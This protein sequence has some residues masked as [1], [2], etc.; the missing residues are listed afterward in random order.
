MNFSPTPYLRRSVIFPFYAF[1]C[2][3][4]YFNKLNSLK[5]LE[6]PFMFV[7]TPSLSIGQLIFQNKK[8]YIPK[9]LLFGYKKARGVPR[10]FCPFNYYQKIDILFKRSKQIQKMWFLRR[11]NNARCRA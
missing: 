3:N 11:R 7:R 2:V 6:D 5:S 10:L 9:Y 4:P 1:F 8:G